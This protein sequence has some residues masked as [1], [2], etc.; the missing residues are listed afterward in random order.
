MRF[1]SSEFRFLLRKK[2]RKNSFPPPRARVF[3]I[4]LPKIAFTPLEKTF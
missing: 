3:E 2:R 1:F 4:K